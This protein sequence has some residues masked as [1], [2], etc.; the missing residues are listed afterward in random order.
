[1]KV[2]NIYFDKKSNPEKKLMNAGLAVCVSAALMNAAFAENNSDLRDDINI[3]I[4]IHNA[5]LPLSLTP[6]PGSTIAEATTYASNISL[7]YMKAPFTAPADVEVR[8]NSSSQCTYRM[9]LPQS[10]AEYNNLLGIWD[11]K[12]LPADWGPLGTPTVSHANTEVHVSVDNLGLEPFARTRQMQTTIFPAG[13]HYLQWKAETRLSPLFDVVLPVAAY[14]VTNII[15]GKSVTKLGDASAQ[16][17]AKQ[18]SIYEKVSETLFSIGLELE[19]ISADLLSNEAGFDDGVTRAVHADGEHIQRFTVYDVLNPLIDTN[20]P[21]LTFE[22]TDFGGTYYDRIR[23]PMLDSII[24]SDPCGREYSLSNDAPFLLELGETDITWT[25]R[26]RGPNEFGGTNTNSLVQKII[27][28]DTQAPLML[29]PPGKVFETNSSGLN[30]DQ[31]SLGLPRVVDLADSQPAVSNDI[32][33]FFPVNSR[34]EVLWQA[35]DASGNTSEGSQLITIKEEGANTTPEAANKSAST[36]TSKPVDIVLTGLD[37]DIIDGI[38]DPLAFV[39][40]QQPDNGEFIAPLYPYFIEDY[41]TQPEGPFGQGFLLASNKGEWVWDNHC[42]PENVPWDAVYQPKFIHVTDEGVQYIYDRYWICDQNDN[43][44][45]TR[46]RVSKWDAEGNYI[47]QVSM[48]SNRNEQFVLDRDGYIYFISRSGAGSSTDLFLT[49][50]STDFSVNGTACDNSWKFN[51]SSAPTLSASQLVYA[52]IDSNQDI[53]YVTDKSNVF[54]FDISDVKGDGEFLGK[55]SSSRFLDSCSAAGISR[56]GFTIEVDSHSNL[57]IADSCADKVHKFEASGYDEIGN[58]VAGDYVGWMGRCDSSTN[59]ACDVNKGVSKG[60]SCTDAT[61]SVS[62]TQGTEQ[63]QFSTPLHMAMDPNDILYVADYGNQRVQR[64]SPDGSFAGEAKST[65]TGINQGTEPGFI[66][67]NFDSPK[68]ISVNSTNFF[69]VDQAESFVHVFETSPLKDVTSDSA[70]VTYVSDFAFHSATDSFTYSVT[71]GLA[72]SS[73]ATV[74]VNVSRNFRPPEVEAISVAGI[75]DENIDIELSGDDP[76]GVIGT[77]D[78][79]ALDT[80]TFSIDEQP[81]HG[82]LVGAGTNWT[83]IPDENFSGEDSF[84]YI[85]SDGVLDS[86]PATVSLS[87]ESVNDAPVIDSITIQD[88]AE[89]FAANIVVNF[90]DDVEHPIENRHLAFIEWGDNTA[91]S[92]NG[93]VL[94]IT[95]PYSTEAAGV[96]SGSHVYNTQGGKSLNVCVQDIEGRQSCKIENF[97]VEQKAALALGVVSSVEEVEVGEEVNY[98]VV[99]VNLQPNSSSPGV[100]AQ[101]VSTIHQIPKGLVPVNIDQGDASCSLTNNQVRCDLGSMVPGEST[102]MNITAINA[103]TQVF[104]S[105]QDF[106]VVSMTSSPATREFYL[107]YLLTTVL[108]DDTDSDGDGIY[109]VFESANGLTDGSNDADGDL[110]GDGLSNYDEFLA[111][112]FANNSDSDNDGISDAWEIRFEMNPLSSIDADIDYDGDGFTNAEEFLADRD[113]RRNEESG[114][115]LVPILSVYDKTLLTVPAVQVGNKHYD[116]DLAL[117]GKNPVV[118]ELIGFRKRDIKVDVPDANTFNPGSLLLDIPA[119]DVGGGLFELQ[120]R[121]TNSAPVELQLTAAKNSQIAP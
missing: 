2:S 39:I 99:V 79:N 20:Q 102:T 118:F 52:R 119:A 15:Y 3:G 1:M 42:Q 120:F 66:L 101:E 43:R 63:G 116:L 58:F 121:L 27:V 68:G 92:S 11:I 8:P 95:S 114:N 77:G 103:G 19:L 110:D 81:E 38:P 56:A 32:P 40:E 16:Q 10:V 85:A 35:T 12:K 88:A 100:T 9:S 117:T 91:D 83:Y 7:K 74:S 26:D 106:N 54:A 33:D 57:Y 115:R 82:T 37:E 108:A 59:K 22:A 90:H 105:E 96:L 4:G 73:P 109:D 6:L 87:V 21:V 14:G 60:Y 70:T 47:G 86:K 84:T 18:A 75:E 49:Q 23:D 94:T 48:S 36:L 34:T 104:D 89:G 98:E 53:V 50:C 55:L 28:E 78:F 72:T 111:G 97:A 67:G 13:N 93:D 64:F 65:G 61:C 69:I 31:I 62:Q 41:R 107:G 44:A 80:L 30:P 112:T 17:A 51:Y 25:V 24:A 113:P 45:Q 5:A 76:D 29:T 71:D 46:Q